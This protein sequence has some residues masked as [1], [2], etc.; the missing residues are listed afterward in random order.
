MELD[1]SQGI[2]GNGDDLQFLVDQFSLRPHKELGESHLVELPLVLES[3]SLGE[4]SSVDETPQF[5]LL[6]LGW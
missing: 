1:V 3:I 5:R 2:R 4:S 6:T